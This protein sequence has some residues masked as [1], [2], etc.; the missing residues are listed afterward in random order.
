MLKVLVT[1]SKG[2]IGS[3]LIKRLILEGYKVVGLDKEYLE[4]E[5]WDQ[6]LMF[7]LDSQNPDVIYHV[8]ACSDTLSLEVQDMMIKNYQ[9]TKILVDWC[10]QNN[11]KIIYSS[12]AANY[13]TNGRY[14]SNLYGWSKYVGEGYV[15]SNDGIALRY[16]N[17]FGPGEHNKG[18]M[19]SFYYQTFV[20]I[21]SGYPII[22]FPNR[23][24]RDFIYIED[25]VEANIY[26]L[27]NYMS[28]K[29]TYYEV[30]TGVSET[31]EAFISELTDKISYE[32]EENMPKGYQSYTCG[33]PSK[34]MT[35]WTPRNTF[36]E[37]IKKYNNYL[38]NRE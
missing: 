28:L 12:S 35:G 27:S 18:K 29:G 10:K 21:N 25:V 3:N 9:S 11:K 24:T 2:F 30:S 14:P 6:K 23:P 20:K 37:S 38:K 31:F 17:V 16:F 22:L 26:A 34:W 36:H 33:N 8:G 1:G 15:I 13:G 5:E 32:Q 4:D 7:Y 19:A